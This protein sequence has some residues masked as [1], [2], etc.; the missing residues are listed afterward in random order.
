MGLIRIPKLNR[1]V[2]HWE[3]SW[4]S[5]NMDCLYSSNNKNNNK[6]PSSALQDKFSW[7]ENGSDRIFCQEKKFLMRGLWK[8]GRKIKGRVQSNCAKAFRRRK[9]SL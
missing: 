9:D 5:E 3:E 1:L 7:E 8:L 4:V 2:T 6:L